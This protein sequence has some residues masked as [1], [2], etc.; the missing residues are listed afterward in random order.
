MGRGMG[1]AILLGMKMGESRKLT[2]SARVRHRRTEF[3]AMTKATKSNAPCAR[4]IFARF[5]LWLLACSMPLKMF[6]TH[7]QTSFQY[8][9]NGSLTNVTAA[10]PG[11][12]TITVPPT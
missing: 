10:V 4:Y 11:P 3:T 7:P 8:D 2:A 1:G 5:A 12:P 6:T 9:L